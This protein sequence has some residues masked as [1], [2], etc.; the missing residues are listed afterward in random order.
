[1]LLLEPEELDAL[2]AAEA[3]LLVDVGDDDRR[4]RRA[5][6]PGAV[7]L[8][9][10]ELVRADPPAMG[11]LPEPRALGERLGRIGIDDTVTVVAYD[12]DG[13]GK[14]GR[15]LWTLDVLGH[16]RHGLL[17]GGLQG[18]LAAE[19]PVEGGAQAPQPREYAAQIRCPACLAD[20]DW[21]R[22]H[23]N[24]PAV[25][26]LDARSWAEYI[27]TDR[28][29][30]RGG[31]IPG[32]VHLDWQALMDPEDPPL[33]RSAAELR[34]MLAERGLADPEQEV[35]VHCQTHHRSSLT[36]VV[37][38]AIGYQRVRGYAGSWSEWGNDPELPVAT[39]GGDAL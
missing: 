15:L 10:G 19:G 24:D 2:R 12:A 36:Y 37:L 7:H 23:L 28:R 18:W 4:Y 31:H 9:Y 16:P 11:L 33:L 27:G 35:V 34:A 38:R 1:M 32:A 3:V 6:L 17:N 29:A 14:A 5:H 25:A 20:R 30:E 22:E 39:S 8:P 21:V 26:I 13:G